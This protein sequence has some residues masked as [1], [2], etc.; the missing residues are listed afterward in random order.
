MRVQNVR[1]FHNCT[2]RTAVRIVTSRRRLTNV[3][4]R[5]NDIRYV[6]LNCRAAARER[7]VRRVHFRECYAVRVASI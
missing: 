6:I 2:F 3:K 4:I 1:A 5:R 7:R